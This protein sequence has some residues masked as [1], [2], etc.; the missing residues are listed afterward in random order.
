[1]TTPADIIQLALVDSGV[2]GQGQTASGEDT[3][4]AAMRCRMMLGQ[5][6]RKRWL[7]YHLVDTAFT[8]T[9]AVSYTVGVGGNFNI[10]RP[11]RLEDGNFF[12]QLIPGSPPNQ[13]DYPLA[14]IQSKED[15]NR[16]T[17]K[18]MGTWPSAIFYDSGYPLGT[19]Y[20]WPVPASGLYAIHILT[21]AVLPASAFELA[22][23]GTDLALP[24]EY[25]A[26]I[27]YNLCARL[28]PAYQLPPDPSIT[29]LA[30]DSL[31]TIR[32]ANTQIPT[33][34]MPASVVGRSRAYNVY[35]DD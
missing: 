24:P 16:I 2:I 34:R 17:L 7:V 1:M 20:V 25:Q 31:S 11:D 6:N 18:Q 35:S 4:K 12:R 27:V 3:S 13:V 14:L 23:L 22:N 5:W 29:A 15:Y 33:L 8:S 28:R 19:I 32:G 26:A 9:G 21:K 10:E 30:L